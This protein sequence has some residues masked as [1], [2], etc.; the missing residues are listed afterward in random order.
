[1]LRFV[2]LL[3]VLVAL[4][5]SPAAAQSTLECPSYAITSGTDLYIPIGLR[6]PVSISFEPDV[7]GTETVSTIALEF[8]KANTAVYLDNGC[9]NLNFDTD[10]DG[11]GDTNIL[12]ASTIEKSGLKNISGFN[13]LRITPGTNPSGT[14]EPYVTVCREVGGR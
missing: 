1:M 6:S 14:D 5:V 8:C 4:W 10:A 11:L 7:T 2:F 9:N 13:Y 3:L 12:D